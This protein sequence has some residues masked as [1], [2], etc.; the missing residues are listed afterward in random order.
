[1]KLEE[2]SRIYCSLSAVAAITERGYLD[3]ARQL[4]NPRI[5][6]ITLKELILVRDRC[7]SP[8]S[9]NSLLGKLRATIRFAAKRGWAEVNHPVFTIKRL[10]AKAPHRREISES[11]RD[12]FIQVINQTERFAPVWFWTALFDVLYYSGIRRKQL[13]HLKWGDLD[14]SSSTI[15][16]RAAGSKNKRERMLPLHAQLTKSLMIFRVHI[17]NALGGLPIDSAMQVFH[18]QTARQLDI[19]SPEEFTPQA[20]TTFFNQLSI[21][22]GRKINAHLLR[23]SFATKIAREIPNIKMVQLLL[24]HDRSDTTMRY[25]HPTLTD[26]RNVMS[27]PLTTK[28]RIGK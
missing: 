10:H 17:E 16:L 21:V 28:E 18:L 8:F 7:I 1:M 14:F 4:G 2:L 12:Y 3:A 13:C 24:N 26:M 25:I 5:R 15:V 11:D 27:L 20:V 6:D 23:H 9:W 19:K 22:S